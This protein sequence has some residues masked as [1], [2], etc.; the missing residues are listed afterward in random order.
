M[1][2]HLN[3]P[4]RLDGLSADLPDLPDLDGVLAELRARG[5]V[6]TDGDRVMNIA[7][8]DVEAD[9]MPR[10]RRGLTEQRRLPIVAL[11]DAAQGA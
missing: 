3:R 2:L 4:R 1:L 11:S 10:P 7:V 8:T 9:P 5:L 6:F